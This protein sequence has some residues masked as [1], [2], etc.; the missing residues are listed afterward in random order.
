M[1]DRGENGVIEGARR[2]AARRR[3]RYAIVAL[4]AAAAVAAGLTAVPRNGAREA[5]KACPTVV[6]I[7]LPPDSANGLVSTYVSHG[8]GSSVYWTSPGGRVTVTVAPSFGCVA[9]TG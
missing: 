9:E 8:T 4:A 3:W 5:S 1:L 2:R 6:T 7:G